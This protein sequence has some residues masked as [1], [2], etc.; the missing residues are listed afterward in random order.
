METRNFFISFDWVQRTGRKL[1]ILTPLE[2]IPLKL[3]PLD[4]IYAQYLPFEIVSIHFSRVYHVK[5]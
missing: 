2:H 4:D 1:Q 5:Y 3:Q